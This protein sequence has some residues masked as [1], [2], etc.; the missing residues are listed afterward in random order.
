MTVGS[1]TGKN[2]IYAGADIKGH[3]LL[4]VFSKTSQAIIAAGADTDGAG[5]LLG[6]FNKTGENVVQLYAEDYGNGVVGAYNRKGKGRQNCELGAGWHL[7]LRL[8]GLSRRGKGCYGRYANPGELP[9]PTNSR[10]QDC[11]S[12]LAYYI[13]I[14]VVRFGDNKR[15]AITAVN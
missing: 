7:K 12:S 4:P 11:K 6:G 10:L 5:F 2:L 1:E 9:R 8:V 15:R 13:L 3:G 14:L